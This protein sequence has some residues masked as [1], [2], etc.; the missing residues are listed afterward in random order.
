MRLML[1][2]S[3]RGTLYVYSPGQSQTSKR[4]HI[5][6]APQLLFHPHPP[7]SMKLAKKTT[8]TL[9]VVLIHLHSIDNGLTP[10]S[11]GFSLWYTIVLL[12]ACNRWLDVVRSRACESPG[13]PVGMT[14][15]RNACNSSSTPC[16]QHPRDDLL[17]ITI[18]LG[19]LG[20]LWGRGSNRF[21]ALRLR[22]L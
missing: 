19:F 7:I 21:I 9:S 13:D 12:D 18:P 20:S 22:Y 4:I 15:A 11:A 17:S 14:W 8:T 16:L 1:G 6:T 3:G 10:Y 5:S 2:K